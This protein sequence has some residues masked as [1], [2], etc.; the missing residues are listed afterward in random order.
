[1]HYMLWITAFIHQVKAVE[2]VWVIDVT[3]F[4]R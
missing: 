1:M 3:N 4:D 2:K